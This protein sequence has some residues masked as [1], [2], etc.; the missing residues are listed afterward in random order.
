M[1]SHH[2]YM[3]TVE[4]MGLSSTPHPTDEETRDP[5]EDKARRGAR[6]RQKDTDRWW[7]T[8]I[9]NRQA[10][11]QTDRDGSSESTLSTGA[12]GTGRTKEATAARRDRNRASGEA[13][14]DEAK[15]HGA[16]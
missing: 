4:D 9:Q 6:D 3:L 8:Q 16:G 10:G 12:M 7:Q 1:E 14:E 11:Y 13:G 2:L 15:P 5:R